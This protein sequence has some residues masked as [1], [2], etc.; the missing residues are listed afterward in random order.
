MSRPILI[1]VVLIVAVLVILF[2]LATL[3][4]EVPLEHVEKPLANVA[5]Q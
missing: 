2:G 1:L 3:D 4:R 5:A